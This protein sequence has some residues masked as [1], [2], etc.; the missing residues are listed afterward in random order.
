MCTSRLLM[1]KSLLTLT[2]LLAL[3]AACSY[4]TYSPPVSEND[5]PCD[6]PIPPHDG[7]VPP[8]PFPKDVTII[9]NDG[10][11][12]FLSLS[13]ST[14]EAQVYSSG[15]FSSSCTLV[16]ERTGNMEIDQ[17]TFTIQFTARF[18]VKPI[19]SV[20]ASGDVCA[21]TADCEGAGILRFKT[22]QLPK[23]IYR[24]KFGETQIGELLVPSYRGDL[25][26][27]TEATAFP[28]PT[29]APA[30]QTPD[31]ANYPPPVTSTPYVYP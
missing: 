17:D 26:L 30:T 19:G 14:F 3:L 9:E 20:R 23:G 24:I 2:F 25:C 6:F 8:T 18:A 1:L 21:C 16:F 22:N 4:P 5:Y 10:R 29:P 13:E 7:I 27:S 31:P 12:C 15:C 11:V 28:I